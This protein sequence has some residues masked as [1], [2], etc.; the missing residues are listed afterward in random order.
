MDTHRSNGWQTFFEHWWLLP[1]AVVAFASS[2]LLSFF[3]RLTG[4]PWIWCYAIGLA[5]AAIGVS[6]VFFAKI[7]LY[8]Q[9]RFVTFGSAALP[10]R[11]RLFYHWG[12]RCIIFAVAL[13]LCLLLSRP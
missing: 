7:P 9:R 10:E 2:Q 11:R 5:V 12:Y 6:L 3:M 1:I 13:L 4:K 8:R